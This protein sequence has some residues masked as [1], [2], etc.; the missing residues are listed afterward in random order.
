MFISRLVKLR[1]K[2]NSIQ[3]DIAVG[4]MHSIYILLSLSLINKKI[5]VIGSEHIVPQYYKNRKLEYFMIIFSTLFLKK[6]TVLS[7]DIKNSF[8]Q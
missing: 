5:N 6:I 1:Q 2:I 4:F 3:P 8:L 7:E